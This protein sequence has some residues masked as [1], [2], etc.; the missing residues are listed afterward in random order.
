MPSPMELKGV[1]CMS[2]MKIKN[3]SNFNIT[4]VL[5]N[6]RYRRDLNPGQEAMLPEDAADEFNFD[7]G[8]RSYVKSGFIK[9]IP[10]ST[11]V[12]VKDIF[13]EVPKDVD[14]NVEELL[15]KKTVNDLAVALKNGSPAFKEKVVSEAIRLS[16][17]DAARCS[18]IKHNCGVDVLNAINLQR[19]VET[20]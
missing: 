9:V 1:N 10:V 19:S 15:T 7:P 2:K 3:T 5:N 16:V 4:I 14:T 12:D 17:T 20:R 18:L 8:C 6:V 11:D 13:G